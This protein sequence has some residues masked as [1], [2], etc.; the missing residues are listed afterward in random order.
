MFKK[1][2]LELLATVLL[3]IG[4]HT[5]R[6]DSRYVDLP[7]F[8]K[9][10]H[11]GARGLMPENTVPAMLKAL[12]LGVTTLEMDACITADSQV[13][14]S[15]DPYFNHFISTH[16]DGRPVTADEEDSLRLFNM[17]YEQT[18]RFDVG[19]RPYDAFPQQEKLNVSKPL[20][21]SLIDSVEDY[22]RR[23]QLARPFYNIETK[24]NPATDNKYHPGPET[25]VRLLMDVVKSKKIEYRTIIQSFDIRTLQLIHKNYPGIRTSLLIEG[26]DNRTLDQQLKTLG[27][28]PDIY[29]PAWKKVDKQLVEACH[30][31]KMKLVPWTV[32]DKASIERLKQMG[33]DGIITD[34]PNLL[35]D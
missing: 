10:G 17:T 25:F 23:N 7:S 35:T 11:R 24:S 4:C 19:I 6:K 30:N 12:D 14:I 16:S 5:I 18:R 13:I 9:E 15:H 34:Y 32:D 27:F 33:V 28:I 1:E 2:I 26:Y 31:R 29:S 21:S 3:I 8:D 20:L 22:C